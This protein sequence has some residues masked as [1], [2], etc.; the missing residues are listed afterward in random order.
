MNIR[1]ASPKEVAENKEINELKKILGLREGVKSL[2]ELRYGELMVLTDED[3]DGIH[4][5]VLDHEFV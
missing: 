5:K 1:D 2:D 4:I 3:V